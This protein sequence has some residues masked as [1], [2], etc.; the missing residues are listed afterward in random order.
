MHVGAFIRSNDDVSSMMVLGSMTV[1]YVNPLLGNKHVA[2]PQ[3]SCQHRHRV[4]EEFDPKQGVS[5]SYFLD[6]N[7]GSS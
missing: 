4:S 6:S 5:V 2:R 3:G 7:S 1:L